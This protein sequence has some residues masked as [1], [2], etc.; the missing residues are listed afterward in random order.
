MSGSRKPRSKSS[1]TVSGLSRQK[2][3]ADSKKRSASDP[4]V[5]PS[6]VK[7]SAD[8]EE[9]SA[10]G[11]SVSSPTPKAFTFER[12]PSID[13]EEKSV[14]GRRVS[15]L[16][17]RTISSSRTGKSRRDSR[18]DFSKISEPIRTESL[19][20]SWRTATQA[21]GLEVGKGNR[22][23]G[24][25]NTLLEEF[26]KVDSIK[27]SKVHR[28][29]L[30]EID[31][32]LE[33]FRNYDSDIARTLNPA[34]K[35]LQVSIRQ[36]LEILEN[37]DLSNIDIDE[38]LDWSRDR[39]PDAMTGGV[40]KTLE[41]QNAAN[42][43]VWYHTLFGEGKAPRERGY[44]AEQE[45]ILRQQQ[46]LLQRYFFSL[47]SLGILGGDQEENKYEQLESFVTK[48]GERVGLATVASGGGLFNFRSSDGSGIRFRN[49]LY[50]LEDKAFEKHKGALEFSDPALGMARGNKLVPTDYL[51]A[52]GRS[53]THGVKKTKAGSLKEVSSRVDRS[54]IGINI[55]IGGV[56]QPLE[57]TTGTRVITDY[58]GRSKD[59]K[60]KS[61]QTGHVLFNH[62]QEGDHGNTLIGFEGSAPNTDNIHG[63][64]HGLIATVK[65]K[66]RGI[67]SDKTLTGQGKRKKWGVASGEL[68]ISDHGGRIAFVDDAKVRVL[69]EQWS[70]FQGLSPEAQKEFFKKLLLT[71]TQAQREALFRTYGLTH[72]ELPP[73]PSPLSEDDLKISPASRGQRISDEKSQALSEEKKMDDSDGLP[74]DSVASRGQPV[75][76]KEQRTLS[77]EKEVDKT[78][79]DKLKHLGAILQALESLGTLPTSEAQIEGFAIDLARLAGISREQVE[80]AVRDR[81][82][83]AQELKELIDGLQSYPD[84][85]SG[86]SA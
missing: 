14:G 7:P 52:Y 84:K 75:F 77:E 42:A 65:K 16:R 59:R 39:V 10:L 25:I 78:E 54:W 70:K 33:S 37:L 85:R 11:S 13:S 76:D 57:T 67:P 35:T 21:G 79:P 17:P 4:S 66:F 43:L 8:S 81:R 18:R 46:E 27:Y 31:Q 1:I 53:A 73:S 12:K 2:S 63:G 9:K 56:G 49:F 26:E 30:R 80:K 20:N 5:S 71:T 29:K 40:R 6:Q 41:E 55:P 15:E 58:H 19:F 23:V 69:Q 62:Y 86:D 22:L 45:G 50:G 68:K 51:G 44:D 72:S 24:E 34:A 74:F 61:Y 32:K 82:S 38:V 64:S 47:A 83:K 36:K 3:S 28:E 60:G 48:D